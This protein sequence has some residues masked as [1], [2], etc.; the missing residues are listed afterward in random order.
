MPISLFPLI[1]CTKDKMQSYYRF[2]FALPKGMV[3]HLCSFH[4]HTFLPF[5]IYSHLPVTQ[6][7]QGILNSLRWN[8]NN[9][10]QALVFKSDLCPLL[11]EHFQP[12]IRG[13]APNPARLEDAAPKPEIWVQAAGTLWASRPFLLMEPGPRNQTLRVWNKHLHEFL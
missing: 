4:F 9:T 3:R 10:T 7:T 1:C 2:P 6:R 12:R 8:C 5:P 13:A 11:D